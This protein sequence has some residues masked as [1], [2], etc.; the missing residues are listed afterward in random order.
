[1]PGSEHP[2]E[3]MQTPDW[4]HFDDTLFPSLLLS[5]SAQPVKGH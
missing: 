3:T 5:L 2:D 1:M 4:K